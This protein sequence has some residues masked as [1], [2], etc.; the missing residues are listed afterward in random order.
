MNFEVNLKNLFEG[1]IDLLL[2]LIRKQ[3]LDICAISLKKV[4]DQYFS[5]L[6]ILEFIDYNI[7]IDFLDVASQLLEIKSEYY[8]PGSEPIEEPVVE[9]RQDFVA[10]LLEYKKYR[11]AAADLEENRLAMQENFARFSNDLPVRA[12]NIAEA[13][14]QR[15][16]LWDLVSAFGR[17]VRESQANLMKVTK[18]EKSIREYM[19]RI[20]S[21]LVNDGSTTFSDLFIPDMPRSELIGV[22][23]GTMELIRHFGVE[24]H[25]YQLFGEIWITRGKGWTENIDLSQF[26][27]YESQSG[28]VA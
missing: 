4:M 7:V 1:P 6:D 26:D 28:S 8:L 19:L 20:Q 11:D 5:F 25:Q 15:V 14:I 21:R 27:N 3:E 17:I 24:A 16:E 13:P 12:S 23:L 10:N 18:K 22:F 9:T 2:Y